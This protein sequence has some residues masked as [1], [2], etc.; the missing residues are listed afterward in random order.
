MGLAPNGYDVVA[1]VGLANSFDVAIN[2]L[3]VRLLQRIRRMNIASIDGR[4]IA[5][6]DNG[7]GPVL[8]LVHGFPLD[9]SMWNGQVDALAS[10]M[11]VIVPDLRGFGKSAGTGEI[12]TMADFA[13]DI[14]RLLVTIGVTSPV[15][16]CGLSM[17]GYVAWQFFAR[18]RTKLASLMICDSRAAADSPEVAE[19]RKKTAA[20]VLAEGASVVAEAMLPKLFA[21]TTRSTKPAIVQATDNVMRGTEPAAISAALLGMASR[22]DFTSTLTS[23][24]LPTLIVCGEH[25]A[26]TPLAEMKTIA[27]AIPGAT[28]CVVEGAGHMSPLEMPEVVNDAIR[29]HVHSV[30]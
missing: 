9:N 29:T 10:S 11:R 25:D 13:D 14:A 26:I 18:H 16:F 3:F 24:D 22:V 28:M 6:S 19:G 20:K 5:Y 12:T 4:A 2:S 1:I 27:A 17:G 15:H 21:E 8:V 23:I 30:K 7:S